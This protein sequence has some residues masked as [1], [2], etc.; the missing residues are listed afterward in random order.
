MWCGVPP[1]RRAQACVRAQGI[2]SLRCVPDA[3][4]A[5]AFVSRM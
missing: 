5:V 3:A 4:V 2:E 1:R